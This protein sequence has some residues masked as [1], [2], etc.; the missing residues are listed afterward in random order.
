MEQLT[1]LFKGL[2]SST[3]NEELQKLIEL[4][5]KNSYTH[6]CSIESFENRIQ[7]ENQVQITVK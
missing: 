4:S 1:P 5:F 2:N 7:N 3:A 6:S